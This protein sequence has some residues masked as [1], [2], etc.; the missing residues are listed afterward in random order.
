MCI[1]AYLQ[2]S[3]RQLTALAVAFCLYTAP[4]LVCQ[5]WY[6][7]AF[8]GLAECTHSSSHAHSIK[9]VHKLLD[10]QERGSFSEFL[11]YLILRYSFQSFWLVC[12]PQLLFTALSNCEDKILACNCFQQ[13]SSWGKGLLH[14]VSSELS[15]IQIVL[16]MGSFQ[17]PP[18]RS[19][20]DNSEGLLVN[21]AL[22]ELQLCSVPSGVC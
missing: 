13:T 3:S 4:K 21:E 10:S 16:Q 17:E 1:R 5:K 18:D 20:S 8:S 15:Q 6:L 9:C 11:W 7:R 14:W 22:N 2:L 12:L 19:N